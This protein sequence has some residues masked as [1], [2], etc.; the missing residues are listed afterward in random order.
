MDAR[1]VSVIV[2]CEGKVIGVSESYG[3]VNYKSRGERERVLHLYLLFY[4]KMDFRS[5]PLRTISI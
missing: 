4:L 1:T 2:I 3:A 5:K